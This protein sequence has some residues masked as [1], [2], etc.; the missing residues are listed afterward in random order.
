[1]LLCDP[2]SP[3]GWPARTCSKQDTGTIDL[4]AIRLVPDGWEYYMRLTQFDQAH[5]RDNLETSFTDLTARAQAD[6]ELGLQF[7]ADGDYAR[8][9]KQ[10]LEAYKISHTYMPRWGLPLLFSS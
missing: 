3:I 1:M 7:E 10:F 6:I 8:A 5:A 9:E 2:G 4:T